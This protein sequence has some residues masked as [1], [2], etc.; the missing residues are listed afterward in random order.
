MVVDRFEGRPRDLDRLAFPGVAP[1]AAEVLRVGLL[2]E[3]RVRILI[4]SFAVE[5]AFECWGPSH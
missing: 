1:A 4:F 3:E 2:A 5:E